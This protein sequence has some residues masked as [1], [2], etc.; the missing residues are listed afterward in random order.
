MFAKLMKYEFRATRNAMA[1]L[2]LTSLGAGLLG[3]GTIGYMFWV[4]GRAWEV[5]T[6][7]QIL[8]MIVMMASVLFISLCGVCALVLTIARFYKSRFTDEG[9]LTFTLPVT[10]HQVLLS[11]ILSSVVNIVIASVTVIASFGIMGVVGCSFV[12]NFWK[13]IWKEMPGIWRAICES[14]TWEIARDMG[15]LLLSMLS[16]AIWQ[17]ISLM[18]AITIGAL[19]AKK[20]KILAAVG[21][22][23]AIQVAMSVGTGVFLASSVMSGVAEAFNAMS[24]L[25]L[26]SLAGL[27][28]SVGGYFLMHYLMARKLNL[29]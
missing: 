16:G 14:M 29:P 5:G 17:L 8:C 2:C 15:L 23:Y 13:V 11:S 22:F 20:H 24:M 4:S 10:T 19:I 1:V 27:V 9:Y 12:E 26:P 25:L 6:T 28:L 21:V 7:G 3:G 18:L